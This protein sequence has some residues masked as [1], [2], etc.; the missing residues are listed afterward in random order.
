MS[1]CSWSFQWAH[2]CATADKMSGIHVCRSKRENDADA[3]AN[4]A[5]HW[6]YNDVNV[7]EKTCH[8]ERYRSRTVLDATHSRLDSWFVTEAT[9]ST[10]PPTTRQDRR[11]DDQQTR[12]PYSRSNRLRCRSSSSSSIGG[13]GSSRTVMAL[14]DGILHA[15]TGA[16]LASRRK[17]TRHRPTDGPA[18][19]P[20]S[21]VADRHG[22]GGGGGSRLDEI[23][24]I[25]RRTDRPDECD[26]RNRPTAS[27]Q[28]SD[29]C[30]TL[31]GCSTSSV[32]RRTGD[33]RTPH[34]CQ[35]SV[36]RSGKDGRTRRPCTWS[37]CQSIL[38]SSVESVQSTIITTTTITQQQ[39]TSND[40]SGARQRCATVEDFQSTRW[41]TAGT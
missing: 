21:V 31:G 17:I 35:R 38:R 2:N 14:T 6:K 23:G 20:Q 1:P 24:S 16:A 10:Q 33:K 26:E 11:T 5:N 15:P 25:V 41:A 34:L 3:N 29:Q 8:C 4:A 13:R 12:Q 40:S 19:P 28:S 27:C 22:G 9:P 18:W 36:V 30:I 7:N 37:W 39:S 32:D